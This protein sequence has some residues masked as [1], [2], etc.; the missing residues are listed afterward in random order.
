MWNESGGPWGGRG[1]S[2]GG[3]GGGDGDGGGLGPR[4]PWSQPPRKRPPGRP[5]G[6]GPSALDEL[7]RRGRARFGGGM[8]APRGKPV[9]LWGVLLVVCIWILMTSMHQID[10]RE[11]GVVIRLGQYAGTLRP[12]ISFSL[13]A[14][15]D[16]VRKVQVENI[17][18]I[19]IGSTS[20]N[21]QNL[22]LTGDQNIIDL[23]YSVRWNVRDP[24]LYLFELADPD[25][26]IREVAESAMRAEIAR[27]TLD[28]AIGPQ[29]SQIEGRVAQR[30]QEILDGYRAGVL[31]QG[32]A[33]KQADPPSAVND[34][35]KEVSAAQQL[36]QTYLNEA[37]AYAQQL[38]Q[39]AEGD[40]AAFDRV[41][42]QYRLAPEVTRKRMYYE[43]MEKVLAKTDKTV[44]EAG[45]V[46][47]Y[48]P[49]PQLRRGG[50]A[51]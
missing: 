30:M 23:A 37:R 11:R 9:W 22:M 4:N 1:S 10:S 5:G 28:D 3:S 12:G 50:E 42:A 27:V 45:G 44:I 40:A 48:L 25:D 39:R 34:A 38:G 31:V 24:E 49:L 35:F 15:I 14:P 8:P 43:T 16:R 18:V 41:Y 32:V 7:L 13:P 21:S 26:T 6:I 33:I 20:E 29:R 2:G 47:Q 51:K 17:R 19:D 36:A 46:T